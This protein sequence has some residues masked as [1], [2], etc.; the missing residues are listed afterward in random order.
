MVRLYDKLAELRTV[1]GEDAVKTKVEMN[2]YVREGWCPEEEI[3]RLEA[4]LRTEALKKRGVQ[5]MDQ[6]VKKV[7]ELWDYCFSGP[8]PWLRLVVP[9]TATRVERQR[10]DERWFPFQENPF[11]VLGTTSD[12]VDGDLGGVT[13]EQALGVAQALLG[14]KGKLL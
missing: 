6:L 4:Q 13:A 14:S 8:K 7:S 11:E 1:G 12:E 9:G 10:L 2:T 3:W 5:T